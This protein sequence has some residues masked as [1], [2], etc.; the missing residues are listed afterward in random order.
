MNENEAHPVY[1]MKSLVSERADIVLITLDTLRFDVAQQL[2]SQDQIPNLSNY[3][4]IDGWECRHTPASFTYA[5]HHA[6]FSG[7]LPTPAS[8]GRHPRL[9]ASQFGGS[10]TIDDRTFVFSE[11]TLPESLSAI[12]YQTICIGGTGFFNPDNSLGQVLPGLFDEAYW[13]P[14]LGVVDRSSETNQIQLALNCL[15]K[16]DDTPVFLFINVSAIHQPNWFYDVS[17]KPTPRTSSENV[18]QP[19]PQDDLQS[20]GAALSAVDQALEPL[21]AF[22]ENREKIEDQRK[23]FFIVCSD[24]GTAYGE[25][26]FVGH[27]CAHE[28]IWN[29]PYTEFVI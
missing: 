29:V 13:S 24:H 4:G 3:L 23:A 9:Y 6:F 8:P 12:G 15:K 10:E 28:V 17:K 19:Q 1:D 26:G 22:F 5:A 27:R 7:F 18:E 16:A 20:H 2:W 21:F 25:N 14:E 11:P